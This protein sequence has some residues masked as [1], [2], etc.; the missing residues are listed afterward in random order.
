MRGQVFLLILMYSIP[1]PPHSIPLPAGEREKKN[2]L[3]AN[4]YVPVV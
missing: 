1:F 2:L 3:T 4:D